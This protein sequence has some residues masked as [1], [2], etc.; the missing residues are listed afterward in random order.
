MDKILGQEGVDNR[1]SGSVCVAAVQ[2]IL[3]FRSEIWVATPYIERIWG[4][5]HHRVAR[6][7]SGKTTNWRAE[8]TWEYPPLGEEMRE[9]GI[10]DIRTYIS[11]RHNKGAE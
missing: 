9:A 2:A 3:L 11:R 10:K 5:F 4:G 8:G 7:I 6:R 1:K